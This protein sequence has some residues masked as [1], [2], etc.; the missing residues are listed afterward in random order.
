MNT[1]VSKI[2]KLQPKFEKISRNIYLRAVKDGFLSC[3]PIIIFS[4]IFMLFAVIP[5]I[6]DFY[7]PDN[8]NDIIM[9]PYQLS[10]GLI[11]V[12]VSATTARALGTSMNREMGDKQLNITALMLTS[13]TG[14]L[15]LSSTLIEDGIS[16]GYLGSKGMIPA[17]LAA[18]ITCNI[19]RVCVKR[20]LTIHLPK[21]VPPSLS[22]SFSSIIP[23]AIANILFWL[24]D[25]C[26]HYLFGASLPESIING[27][28]P[29][30]SAADGYIGIGLIYLAMTFLWF[31]GIHG[32][33]VVEPA[34][35][36]IALMNN[37]TNLA[38]LQAGEHADKI[39]T[40][41]LINMAAFGGTG[42]T[43]VLPFLLMF[44]CKSK[45]LKAVGKTS[46][47]PTMFSVNEPVIF[48]V[49]LVLNP[50]LLIPFLLA[51]LANVVLF[52]FFVEVFGMNS[53]SYILPWC[54]PGPL[55]LIIGTGFHWLSFV[56]CA[57][58]LVVD[59]LIYLPFVKAYDFSLKKQED[60]I[61]NEAELETINADET[62]QLEAEFDQTKSG[63]RIL[64]LCAG[65]GTSGLLANAIAKG[66]EENGIDM[67]TRADAY[68]AHS[69][70]LKEYDLVIL[71]P[72]VKSN[73]AD[74][75]QETDKLGVKLVS[76]DGKTYIS[77]TRDSNSALKFALDNL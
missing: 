36:S 77:L 71:A 38:L 59:I 45:Q 40:P 47:V 73:Y 42:A 66:A 14:F 51:P 27:L 46:V 9:K 20:N 17:F 23:F 39:L 5:N 7:W 57:V 37:E 34:I 8:V 53:F 50:N 67:K 2:E 75:K 60:E 55:W 32:P 68:G 10:M 4:S 63:Q 19:Y 56:L 70:I 52:K 31:I 26:I 33:S 30:F 6:F 1:I 64:V 62:I 72:Q 21:E 35:I 44:I 48:G 76:T 58:I 54:T 24:A 41:G 3:M 18:F 61:K 65:G 13:M 43:F 49:P 74:I 12:F 16:N 11:A 22:Q 15:L 28:T 69:E 29:L 25:L